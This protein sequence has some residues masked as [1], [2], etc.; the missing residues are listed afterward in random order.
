MIRIHYLQG[1]D[2]EYPNIIRKQALAANAEAKREGIVVPMT[3]EDYCLKPTRKPTT[4][5]ANFYDDDFDLETED[6]LP[7]DDDDFEDDEED[8]EEDED[9]SATASISKNNGGSKCNN[10][11][12]GHDAAV[13]GVPVDDAES[14]DDS[15]KGETT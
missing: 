12:L 3:L 1:K 2:N 6:D 8:E 7:T 13:A 10:N 15:G 4:E 11:G 14:A 5:S 9:D